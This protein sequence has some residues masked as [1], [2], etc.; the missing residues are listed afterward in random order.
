MKIVELFAGTCSFSNVA[1]ERG[2][3]TFTTDF[4][5]CFNVNL[6]ADI[7]DL[8]SQRI[9]F[10][11]IKDA[12]VV[13]MSPVCTYWSLSAGNTYWTKFRMPRNDKAIEGIKMMMFCRFVADYCVKHNKIFFI[14]NPNGRAVWILDN[15][16]L[17]RVW[18]C[19][20]GDSRAKPTNIWT[21]L[22]IEF[23]T[24]S[25]NNKN[26]NHES[27]PRGSK[28]GTQGLK[29]SKERSV[30][31]R[32][33]CLEI[34]KCCESAEKGEKVVM[35]K[36]F[37][38]IVEWEKDDFGFWLSWGSMIFFTIFFPIVYITARRNV[39]YEEIKQSSQKR[40]T[41]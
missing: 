6:V 22:N 8:E 14:E 1:K 23:K 15:Q 7:L 18:Y 16:Y 27:A 3:K 31:P 25:N 40:D 35:T 39:H 10:E 28:T 21:N 36:K 4:D 12:D 24:C 2:H 34:I 9:V 33:L 26:C 5:D 13:W 17:K 19:Q 11:E 37:K 20:Y 30:V 32:D 41:K 38:K 29:G